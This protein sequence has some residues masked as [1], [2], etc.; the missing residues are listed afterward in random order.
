MGKRGP[1]PAPTALKVIRGDKPS[2]I[3]TGEPQPDAGEVVAPSWLSRKA[4]Y[5]WARLAPD[6]IKKGV[7][8]TW[9]VDTF[10]DFCSLVVTNREAIA[11]VEKHGNVITTVI[12][13]LS[14]G[15]IIYGVSKN[16]NWQ[17]AKESAALL[18]TIGGRFGLNPS[19]RAQLNVGE[20]EKGNAKGRLLS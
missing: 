4:K 7:L 14:D 20:P 2:R 8:T 18:V 15:T 9:D 1:A 6:L 19:D 5:V 13:E 17:I 16:P 3:P 12:R 10:A 11:D